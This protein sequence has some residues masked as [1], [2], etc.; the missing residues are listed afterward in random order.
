LRAVQDTTK[1]S[2]Q[3]LKSHL[4]G[5]C[6]KKLN[7]V[8]LHF[9]GQPTRDNGKTAKGTVWVWRHVAVGFTGENGLRGSRVDTGSGSLLL[10]Q[11]DTRARGPAACRT[12]TVPRLTPTVVSSKSIWY[13]HDQCVFFFL[14]II[15]YRSL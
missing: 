2:V 13:V 9:S 10:L 15:E 3:F 8:K 7:S 4:R 14:Q 6:F 12:V 1:L 5:S 11:Q